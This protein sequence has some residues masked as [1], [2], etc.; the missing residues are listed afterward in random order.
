MEQ[1]RGEQV[2]FG[3][4]FDFLRLIDGGEGLFDRVGIGG[5]EKLG[6]SGFRDGAQLVFVEVG[7]GAAVA[8]LVAVVIEDRHRYEAVAAGAD[9]V[10]RHA[11]GFGDVGGLLRREQAAIIGAIGQ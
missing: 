9:G 4:E 1:L 3:L 10:D 2:G 7:D 8:D 11:A 5:A 6:A